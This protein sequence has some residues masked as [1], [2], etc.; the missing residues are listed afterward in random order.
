[1]HAAPS[2]LA[3]GKTMAFVT[4]RRAVRF[5]SL[6]L[7]LAL[8]IAALAVEPKSF[9]TPEQAVDA[10]LAATKADDDAALVAIFGDKH[11]GLVASA[12]KAQNSANR[13]RVA[14][15]LQ[16]YH[17]LEERGNDRRILLIGYEAWPF[18]VPIV[19][20]AQGWQFA[21]DE[22][23]DEIISRRIGANELKAIAVLQAYV[24][25]Q[26]AICVERPHGRR[27][28]PVRATPRQLAEQAR[29]PVLA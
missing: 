18:P 28:A 20:G 4:L 16:S 5:V 24:D 6:S 21:T 19:R 12:D 3:M 10:L 14:A 26:E 13:A 22:G 9:A 23:A 7:L 17:Q 8:P 11:A 1:M 2:L 15:A 29:R 25:A 27:R